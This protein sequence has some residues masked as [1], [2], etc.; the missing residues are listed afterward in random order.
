MSTINEVC[1][2]KWRIAHWNVLPWWVRRESCHQWKWRQKRPS[3]SAVWDLLAGYVAKKQEEKCHMI[4]KI[5]LYHCMMD[6]Q[7]IL[8]NLK[9]LNPITLQNAPPLRSAT[10][11]RAYLSLAITC[12]T[13]WKNPT[14]VSFLALF[15]FVC[16]FRV[17]A[18]FYHARLA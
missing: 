6:I 10:L 18:G 14:P 16:L 9:L 7:R 17:R 2:I 3:I 8:A 15:F 4:A 12:R 1:V 5:L 11:Q 13:G